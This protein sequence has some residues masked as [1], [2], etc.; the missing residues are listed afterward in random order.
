[1]ISHGTK[2]RL[3]SLVR[4]RSESLGDFTSS[5]GKQDS[6]DQALSELQS[7]RRR[8][9]LGDSADPP[10]VRVGKRPSLTR[11]PAGIEDN[12]PLTAERQDSTDS[13]LVPDS[14]E[15][16]TDGLPDL[17]PPVLDS[18]SVKPSSVQSETDLTL[19]ADHTDKPDVKV[20]HAHD[21]SK[22]QQ[23]SE[24]FSSVTVEPRIP[25]TTVQSHLTASLHTP[26]KAAQ[27]GDSADRRS[28]VELMDCDI[29]DDSLS[30][31]PASRISQIKKSP[32]KRLRG[33]SKFS[34]S[35]YQSREDLESSISGRCKQIALYY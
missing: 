19:K 20:D 14:A 16:T 34:N 2:D 29:S 4:K 8:S 17:S 27:H 35:L 33:K 15:N 28:G 13:L 25:A 6:L 5:L 21:T 32:Q 30:A 12:H 9:S 11:S 26:S 18:K 23:E 10:A 1:M 31:S 22:E 3:K 7:L 24:S